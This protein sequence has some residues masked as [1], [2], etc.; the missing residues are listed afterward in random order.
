MKKR[1]M[2]FLTGVF[3]LLGAVTYSFGADESADKDIMTPKKVKKPYQHLLVLGD[4]FHVSNGTNMQSPI[5]AYFWF[6]ENFKNPDL[7]TQVTVTT[8]RI[9]A[10]AA[11]KTNRVYTGV[12]PLIEH[13][14]YAGWRSYNRGYLDRGR[15]IKGNNVGMTAFF[16]YNWLRILSTRVFVHPS[17]H[18]YH[19]PIISK[20]DHKIIN[21]PNNHWQVKPGVEMQLSDLEQKDLNRVLHGYLFRV[22]YQYARRIGY[23]TWYDYDRMWFRER[24]DGMWLPGAYGSPTTLGTWYRSKI[25]DTHRL[26]FNT[27]GYYNFKGD[28]NL[29][30]DFYG[31][32]FTG[33]D[34]NNAEQIGYNQADHAVMPGYF[35]TEFMSAFYLIARLQ[36]GIPIPVWG[37]RIQPGFNVLYMPRTNDVI[38]IGRNN[39]TN[40]WLKG[41][42]PN[43]FYKSVSCQLSV[44]L[45]NLLPLFIDYAYGIDAVRADS[46]H[47]VYLKK[48]SQ[49]NHEFRV[50]L[51]MGFV[52]NE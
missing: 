51:V 11:Y 13:S 19:F 48:Y 24:Y 9:F 36:V 1:M 2:C 46:A 37:M 47:E 39:I 35:N 22:E 27:G 49:G 26:Y 23:G 38:G 50:M 40:W 33:V 42:Y 16:Q 14:T 6:G 31:G 8:T 45:G 15:S 30:F 34:R 18:F 7:Y 17:Y 3:F 32:F 10:I 41:G 21:V 5:F 25:K 4:D 29:L 28:Y 43:R 44:K 52:K 20:N 12:K